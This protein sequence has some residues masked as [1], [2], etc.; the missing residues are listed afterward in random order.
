M[1]VDTYDWFSRTSLFS[2]LVQDLV[3]FFRAPDF[4]RVFGIP[5]H[6]TGR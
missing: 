3:I 4:T 1:M 5:D 6:C 2:Y